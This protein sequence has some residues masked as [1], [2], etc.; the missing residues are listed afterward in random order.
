MKFPGPCQRT[1]ASVRYA[2]TS[3]FVLAPAALGG[4]GLGSG[5]VHS[6]TRTGRLNR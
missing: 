3:T 2:E 6:L 4:G 1:F 5:T